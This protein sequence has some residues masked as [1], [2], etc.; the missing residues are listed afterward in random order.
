M[1]L[2]YTSSP[3]RTSPPHTHT[4][5]EECT[6][7]GCT[8]PPT[9]EGLSS[10]TLPH[11]RRLVPQCLRCPVGNQAPEVAVVCGAS[12]LPP[13]CHPGMWLSN[14]LRIP[15]DVPISTTL[16]ENITGTPSPRNRR[17]C[18]F[19][20]GHGCLGSCEAAPPHG[21]PPRLPPAR[22][23]IA[24]LQKPK[25]RFPVRSWVMPPLSD[26]ALE[27][28]LVGRPG[29]KGELG[30]KFLQVS[31]VH[32]AAASL[33]SGSCGSGGPMLPS[34]L[35]VGSLGKGLDGCEVR[36]KAVC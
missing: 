35:W 27:T 18:P 26:L 22:R 8:S 19:P 17:W 1:L 7:W 33:T 23:A 12:L 20:A 16:L 21:Q 31:G 36:E 14:C 25:S 9:Q 2:I 28:A 13:V 34:L 5:K 6:R 32:S 3:S 24:V 15:G 29:G 4:G 30:W 11:A 10:S